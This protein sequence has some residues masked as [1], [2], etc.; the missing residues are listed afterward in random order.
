MFATIFAEANERQ[1]NKAMWIRFWR[2]PTKRAN[3]EQN[4]RAYRA[5]LIE[6]E[7]QRHNWKWVFP[8]KRFFL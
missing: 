7:M 2:R 8:Q 4:E 6:R 3:P 1:A 5:M